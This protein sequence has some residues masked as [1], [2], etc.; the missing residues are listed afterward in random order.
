MPTL[1]YSKGRNRQRNIRKDV[2]RRKKNEE[3]AKKENN[4][5]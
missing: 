2:Q 5:Y 4:N 3:E 1:A